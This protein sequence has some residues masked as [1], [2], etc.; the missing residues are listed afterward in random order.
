MEQPIIGWLVL[1][2]PSIGAK[3]LN[4]LLYYSLYYALFNNN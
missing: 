3:A 2:V 1:Y 4:G